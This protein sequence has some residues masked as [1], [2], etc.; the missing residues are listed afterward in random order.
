MLHTRLIVPSL[1]QAME[2]LLPVHPEGWAEVQDL[3][4]GMEYGGPPRP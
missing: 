4:V 1:D 3:E 2:E